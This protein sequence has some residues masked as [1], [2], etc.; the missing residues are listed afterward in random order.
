[1]DNVRAGEPVY[2]SSTFIVD[3]KALLEGQK[4]DDID[5]EIA[6]LKALSDQQANEIMCLRQRCTD[7]GKTIQKLE[8]HIAAFPNTCTVFTLQ[9]GREL[10]RALG[11]ADLDASSAAICNYALVLRTRVEELAARVAELTAECEA[12]ATRPE[13]PAKICTALKVP[14]NIRLE[15]AATAIRSLMRRSIGLRQ[16]LSNAH[17]VECSLKL[18]ANQ[19]CSDSTN[20]P[21]GHP[22][23]P[24]G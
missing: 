13:V 10:A 3:A 19:E 18:D 8:T 21:S 7:R 11:M 12:F 23:E 14:S 24:A 15:R 4:Q 16:L 2:T 6:K 9:E 17:I 5:K 1:M 20:I 22:D